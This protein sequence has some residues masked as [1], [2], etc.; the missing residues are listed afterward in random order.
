MSLNNTSTNT[1]D[2]NRTIY[3]TGRD[4]SRWLSAYPDAILGFVPIKH[5]IEMWVGFSHGDMRYRSIGA[6]FLAHHDAQFE[7]VAI[8][9]TVIMQGP[10]KYLELQLLKSMF[11]YSNMKDRTETVAAGGGVIGSGKIR[12]IVRFARAGVIGAKTKGTLVARHYIHTYPFLC[13]EAFIPYSYIETLTWRKSTEIPDALEVDVLLRTW[14]NDWKEAT[15]GGLN[16][17]DLNTSKFSS[18]GTIGRLFWSMAVG[19]LALGTAC[20]AT[21]WLGLSTLNAFNA[22]TKSTRSGMSSSSE[23]PHSDDVVKPPE[24]G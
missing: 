21:G 14:R 19:P 17:T 20:N 23:N 6:L 16:F 5:I 24:D 13:P 1:M 15:R 11:D 3:D 9:F 18:V 22:S 12:S 7:D 10:S 2:I 4:I 8:R